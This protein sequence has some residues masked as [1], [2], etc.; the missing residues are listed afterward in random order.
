[1]DYEA[2]E[3]IATYSEEELAQEAAVCTTYGRPNEL[4]A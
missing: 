2:P 4:P 3:V 1:M